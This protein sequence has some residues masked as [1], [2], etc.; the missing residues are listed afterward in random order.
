MV[1]TRSRH[2]RTNIRLRDQAESKVGMLMP[3]PSLFVDPDPGDEE[4]PCCRDVLRLAD[5]FDAS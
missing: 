2:L 1:S 4:L 3:P 5:P